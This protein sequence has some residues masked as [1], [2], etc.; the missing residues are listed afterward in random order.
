[1]SSLVDINITYISF[2]LEKKRYVYNL[3]SQM[4]TSNIWIV[5]FARL[6]TDLSLRAE[7]ERWLCLGFTVTIRVMSGLLCV[8]LIFNS[9]YHHNQGT[10]SL[11]QIRVDVY[12]PHTHTC[13]SYD[14][15]PSPHCLFLSSAGMRTCSQVFERSDKRSAWGGSSSAF[16][17]LEGRT[18]VVIYNYF[19]SLEL[20][21]QYPF[22]P[23][24]M[25]LTIFETIHVVHARAFYS[26]NGVN[27]IL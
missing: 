5:I 25:F 1:M 8:W 3:F 26:S 4:K 20:S 21:V 24:G 19:L 23:L 13:A 10:V 17:I 15:R 27:V 16:I 18:Y 2:I 12:T 7:C 14:W 9:S 11:K 22:I 6:Q